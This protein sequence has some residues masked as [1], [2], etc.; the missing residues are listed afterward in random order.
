LAIGLIS[1]AVILVIP[2][3]MAV[4]SLDRLHKEARGLQRGEF[5]ASLL[6]GSLREGLSELRRIETNAAVL[7]DSASIEAVASQ[8]HDLRLMTDSLEHYE[9]SDAASDVRRSVGT[10]ARWGPEEYEAARR[11]RFDIAD[12]ISAR[13]LGP[14]LDSADIAVRAA[15]ANLRKRTAETIERSAGSLSRTKFVAIVGLVLAILLATIIGFWLTRFITKPVSALEAGMRAVADGQL[16]YKLRY[17]TTK[18]HEF[19]H[20]ARS[21]DERARQ[22]AELDKLKAEFVSVASHELKTPINVIIG[23]V[24]LLEEGIYGELPDKQ[25]EVLE[26]VNTQ[27][28]QL[29]RLV[30]QL[31]DVSR[32]EAGGGRIE[33]RPVDLPRMLDDLERAFAVLALQREVKFIVHRADDLPQEVIWDKD[34]MN[35]VLGNLLS[36]AFKFTKQNGEVSLNVES[37]G[38]HIEIRVRDTGAGIPPEQ[39]SRIFEKFYQADNQRS[40]SA[41]GTGLGLAI[42]K[43]IVEAHDGR[44]RCESKIGVGTTFIIEVP[45][46]VRRRSM[47]SPRKIPKPKFPRLST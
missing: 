25:K 38:D 41:V 46:V 4:Q 27:T 1:I 31:L 23:Y 35:E 17:D 9:L 36:N 13:Y 33:P 37:A 24:Q 40:A 21:F 15:E 22:L 14:A 29:Q 8:I 3:L 10:I 34:R 12:T 6:L 5:A 32:F 7:H 39:V 42:V 28:A 45:T 19:G 44:I 20:L 26:T 11:K 18:D 43:S 47:S 2:L 30:Q 16:D